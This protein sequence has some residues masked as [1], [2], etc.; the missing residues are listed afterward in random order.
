[1]RLTFI[2]EWTYY[3]GIIDFTAHGPDGRLFFASSIE[4]ASTYDLYVAVPIEQADLTRLEDGSLDLRSLLLDRGHREWYVACIC[5]PHSA[6]WAER[7]SGPI[8]AS[9]YLPEPGFYY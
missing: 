3:D 1:M 6:I 4:A 9:G 7:Q 2:Q 8:E 5:H